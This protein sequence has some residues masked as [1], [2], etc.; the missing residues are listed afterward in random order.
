MCLLAFSFLLLLG[1]MNVFAISDAEFGKRLL[2]FLWTRG[3][4]GECRCVGSSVWS[5]YDE[6]GQKLEWE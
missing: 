3:W 5:R 1:F 2:E 4:L 6:R